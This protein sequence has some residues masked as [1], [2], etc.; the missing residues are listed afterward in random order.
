MTGR[1]GCANLPLQDSGY[2][3]VGFPQAE[4]ILP[5]RGDLTVSAEVL[6]GEEAYVKCTAWPEWLK[7]IVIFNV[8]INYFLFIKNS[9]WFGLFLSIV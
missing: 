8:S 3:F 4:V 9:C 6:A 7:L 5:F 2:G 1:Q